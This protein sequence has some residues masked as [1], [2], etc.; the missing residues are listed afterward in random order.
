[1]SELRHS[2]SAPTIDDFASPVGAPLI[3][4]DATGV[5]YTVTDDDVAKP[6]ALIVENRT[7]DPPDPEIGRIWLRTDL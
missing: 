1:M 4:N 3:T 7:D 5:L 6:I 2:A